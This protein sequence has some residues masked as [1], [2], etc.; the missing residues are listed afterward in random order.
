M[1][2]AGVSQ[3]KT[4]PGNGGNLNS[5]G[6]SEAQMLAFPALPVTLYMPVM[7]SVSESSSGGSFYPFYFLLFYEN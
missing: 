4:T 2:I 3:E 1:D 5:S 6:A 7:G